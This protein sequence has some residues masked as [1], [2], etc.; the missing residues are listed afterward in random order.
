MISNGEISLGDIVFSDGDLN[1]TL[2]DIFVV[3]RNR[4]SPFDLG[5]SMFGTRNFG[6]E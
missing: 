2:G 4:I 3:L 1:Y 5:Q 6:T